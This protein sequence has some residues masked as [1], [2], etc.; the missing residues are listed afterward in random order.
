MRIDSWTKYAGIV[1]AGALVTGIGYLAI[2]DLKGAPACNDEGQSLKAYN[3]ALN[4]PNMPADANDDTAWNSWQRNMDSIK[5]RY[6]ELWQSR[7]VALDLWQYCQDK[8]A[9]RD[10]GQ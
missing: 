10:A 4:I 6:P 2:D 8:Q 5:A 3:I 9:A 1:V 7:Q